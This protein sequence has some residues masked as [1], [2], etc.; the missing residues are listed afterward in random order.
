MHFKIDENLPT[1]LKTLINDAG[2]GAST[3]YDKASQ[4]LPTPGSWRSAGKGA[5]R[6]SP[7]TRFC[8]CR[9]LPAWVPPRR[10]VIR[11]GQLDAAT[12]STVVSG[13]LQSDD[14][15][16]LRGSIVIVEPGRLRVRG[17]VVED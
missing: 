9:H 17:P 14:L 15:D 13:L 10:F 3:V 2:H 7:W 6:S 4:A 11:A 1:R 5:S 12:I 16:R 8:E